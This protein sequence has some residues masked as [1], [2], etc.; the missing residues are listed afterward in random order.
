MDVLVDMGA[1]DVVVIAGRKR[2]S[3]E[4][5]VVVLK[6]LM[7]TTP[8]KP[9]GLQFPSEMYFRDVISAFV[10]LLLIQNNTGL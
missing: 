6:S 2:V 4:D 10:V 7:L 3:T 8:R 9:F 1:L 5:P